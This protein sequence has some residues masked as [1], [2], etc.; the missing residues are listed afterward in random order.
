VFLSTLVARVGSL[1][2]RRILVVNADEAGLDA[3]QDAAILDAFDH[4][5][6]R[7]ASVVANGPTAEAFVRE[8]QRRHGFSLGLH[9]NLTDGRALALARS[10]TLTGPSG[11]FLGDKYE[12][13]RRAVEGLV[14]S[15]EV[16][17]EVVAQWRKLVSFGVTPD[18]VDGREHVHILPEIA[19][20]V[21]EGLSIVKAHVFVRVPDEGDPP[22]GTPIVDVPAIPVGTAMLSARRLG[23]LRAGHTGLAAVGLHADRLRHRLASPLRTTDAFLGLALALTPRLE[24][25]DAGLRAAAG[26]VVEWS[27]HPGRLATRLTSA[28]LDARRG[29]QL[30]L[31]VDPA[32]RA[33]LDAAGFMLGSFADATE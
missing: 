6:V 14:D 11:A 18:H 24:H 23:Q 19:E 22:P 5:I 8:A 25:F 3:A 27:V 16:S 31:L 21:L 7:S 29:E 20:G 33:V 12:V 30:R 10:F 9:I 28:S 17:R 26:D 1:F 13:W 15:R 2:M 32:T 4:G